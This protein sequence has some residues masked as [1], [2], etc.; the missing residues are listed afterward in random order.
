MGKEKADYWVK[1]TFD[2]K[3][4]LKTKEI[5]VCADD[6]SGEV[7]TYTYKYEESDSKGNWTKSIE[8]FDGKPLRI[9]I[10]EILY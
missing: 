10:R 9:I 5:I 1:F 7:G 3:S 4:R 2:N 8:Y 6:I